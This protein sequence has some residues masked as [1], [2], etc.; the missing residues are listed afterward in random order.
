MAGRLAAKV[1]SYQV[2]D[3]KTCLRLLAWKSH[4]GESARLWVPGSWRLI[5]LEVPL[6]EGSLVH[7]AR[8]HQIWNAIAPLEQATLQIGQEDQGRLA[9][10]PE[11][12]GVWLPLP[13]RPAH[14]ECC[15]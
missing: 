8:A 4:V 7:Q 1:I 9:E 2:S 3:C 12:R 11:A 14:A 6:P 15:H 5:A 13:P 10:M